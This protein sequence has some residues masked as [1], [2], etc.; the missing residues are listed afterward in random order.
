ML[1]W[2]GGE[3]EKQMKWE[4]PLPGLRVPCLVLNKGLLHWKVRFLV[5]GLRNTGNTVSTLNLTGNM[6]TNLECSTVPV[7]PRSG[8]LDR[9]SSK[10]FPLIFWERIVNW[11]WTQSTEMYGRILLPKNTLNIAFFFFLRFYLFIYD[12]ERE[13]QRHRQREKQAP[14]REPEAGLNPGLRVMSWAEGRR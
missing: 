8:V 2:V 10:R 11:H 12:R 3:D 7:F 14:C 5:S 13:R 6:E 1:L 4:I 9:T